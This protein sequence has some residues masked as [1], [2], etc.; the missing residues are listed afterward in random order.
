[1]PAL[2]LV[3][4]SDQFND[5]LR[6]LSAKPIFDVELSNV[7]KIA[8]V[9]N[10]WERIELIDFIDSQFEAMGARMPMAVD[11]WLQ[12]LAVASVAL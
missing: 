8:L 5:V 4:K 12:R 9:P 6:E 3:G 7:K 1:M 11:F 10:P 2:T